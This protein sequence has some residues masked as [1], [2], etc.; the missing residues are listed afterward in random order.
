MTTFLNQI[1]EYKWLIAS[2]CECPFDDIDVETI[3]EATNLSEIDVNADG[4]FDWKDVEYK[5][6]GGVKCSL[7]EGSDEYLDAM[8][9][10]NLQEYLIFI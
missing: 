9:K 6:L 7:V 4:M 3:D 2:E 8:I 10:G 1:D 5:I